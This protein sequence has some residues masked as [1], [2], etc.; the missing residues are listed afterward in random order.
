ML[1][2][3]FQYNQYILDTLFHDM[4][5][6]NCIGIFHNDGKVYVIYD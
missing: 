1:I 6:P 5:D 3:S 2:V 4:E